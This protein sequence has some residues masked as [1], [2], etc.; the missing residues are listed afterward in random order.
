MTSIS[1][2]IRIYP[3]KSYSPR[4]E[5]EVNITMRVDKSLC[6]PKLK[7]ITILLY[8]FVFDILGKISTFTFAISNTSKM[9]G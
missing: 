5:A 3:K 4:P 9:N 1:V 2:D 7:S 6:Q 8:V